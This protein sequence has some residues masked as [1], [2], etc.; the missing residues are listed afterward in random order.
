MSLSKVAPGQVS[1]GRALVLWVP[2]IENP[3]EPTVEELTATGVIDLTYQ[4]FGDGFDH[5][6]EVTKF[7][8]TRYTLEQILEQEGTIKDTITLRYP[9]MGT[10]EDEVRVG[11]ARGTEGFIVE[12]LATPNETEVAADQLLSIVAP[13]RAGLQRDIPRTANTEI[14]K[15]Q[16]ILVTGRVERDVKIAA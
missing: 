15:V 9:Y 7:D 4:L 2:A 6:T 3:G 11:L 13:A 12:R 1:D 10:E 16:D 14:G 5:Q 8:T